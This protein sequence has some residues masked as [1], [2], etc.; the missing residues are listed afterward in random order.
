MNDWMGVYLDNL[1]TGKSLDLA[2]NV[3]NLVLRLALS[4][5]P[6]CAPLVPTPSEQLNHTSNRHPTKKDEFLNDTHDL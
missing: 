4:C 3:L 6:K 1:N 2:G 5:V